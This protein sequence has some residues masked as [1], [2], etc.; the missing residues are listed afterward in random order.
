[1]YAD[2]EFL[3]RQSGVFPVDQELNLNFLGKSNSAVGDGFEGYLDT[4]MMFQ[5][6]LEP[7]EAVALFGVRAD[8]LV[9]VCVYIYIYI[10]ILC[11]DVRLYQNT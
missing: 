3:L 8:R 9:C 1:V 10:Y 7:D 2:G 11:W 6:A 5:T 4:F